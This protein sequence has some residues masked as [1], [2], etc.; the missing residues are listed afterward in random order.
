LNTAYANGCFFASI[1]LTRA[2]LDHVPPLFGAKDF[3][4]VA[5]QYPAPRSFKEAMQ[6]LDASA[7]KI[8]DIHLHG[9]VRKQETLPTAQQVNFAQGLDLLLA[10]IVRISR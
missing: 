8:A 3:T 2:I 10:E 4:N 1:M 9:Q 5:G 7:R 6:N